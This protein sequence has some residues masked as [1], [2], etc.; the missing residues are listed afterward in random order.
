MR[1]RVLCFGRLRE[2]LAPEIVAELSSPATVEDLWRSLRERFPALAPYE[3]SIA[4]AVNQS[5]ASSSTPLAAGDEIALLPPVSGGTDEPILPL[6]S[7][8]TR[9]QREPI[10]SAALLAQIKEGEDGAVCLFDGIVRN[11]SRNRRTLYLEYDAYPAMALA[12]MERLALESLSRFP[13]RDVRIVHR[14]GRL[15]PAAGSSIR[16]R[17]PCQSG[18]RNSSKTAQPGPTANHFHPRFRSREL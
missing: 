15:T 3:G 7:A 18:R 13:V 11:H 9:L 17:K 2:L 1:L 5:F 12:E 16:S 6:S 14:V 10:S 8:H 4:I